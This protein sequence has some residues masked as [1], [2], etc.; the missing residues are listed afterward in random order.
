MDDRLPGRLGSERRARILSYVN[1]HGSAAA[2]ELEAS[3]RIAPATLYRDLAALA[4]EGVI[5]RVRG[6]AMAADPRDERPIYLEE[7][8]NVEAKR[9]V[10]AKAAELIR[11]GSTVFLE[12]STTVH[13]MVPLLRDVSG[14]TAVTNSPEIALD[15]VRG[16]VEVVLIGGAL[17]Q[18]TRSTV[19]PMAVSALQALQ[20]ELAFVGVSAITA[21]GLA[22]MNLSEGETKAAI[23]ASAERAVA[24]ADASKLGRRGLV[25]VCAVTRLDRLIVDAGATASDVAELEGAGLAVVLAGRPGSQPLE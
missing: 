23:I 3:L 8:L 7:R 6:G 19:G 13:A 25:H 24:L 9:A 11:P 17:R 22:S 12:A 1:E 18:R 10:A 16:D 21:D 4:D 15:L 2:A 14:L 20:V 5:R